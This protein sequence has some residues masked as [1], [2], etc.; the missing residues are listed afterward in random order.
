M[1]QPTVYQPTKEELTN[2]FE[3]VK[4]ST[5]PPETNQVLN[6][7]DFSKIHMPGFVNCP[8]VVGVLYPHLLILHH[9]FETRLESALTADNIWPTAPGVPSNIIIFG[10]SAYNVGVAKNILQQKYGI[11]INYT[12]ELLEGSSLAADL[13]VEK[14]DN[15]LCLSFYDPF[16][17]RLTKITHHLPLT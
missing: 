11:H 6:I 7:A 5:F 10:N 4:K 16:N 1:E 2:Y 3:Q 17:P 9:H 8:A 15:T 13:L 14:Q 12:T